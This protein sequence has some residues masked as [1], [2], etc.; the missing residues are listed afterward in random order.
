MGGTQKH[1][2]CSS[3]EEK[4]VLEGND[5][6]NLSYTMWGGQRS[7]GVICHK[8]SLSSNQEDLIQG[9]T[10]GLGGRKIVP[11][12]VVWLPVTSLVSLLPS[13]TDQ[14]DSVRHC[15]AG[16]RSGSGGG[17]GGG[18]EVLLG[19]RTPASSQTAN[20]QRQPGGT[21]ETSVPGSLLPGC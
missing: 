8:E 10:Q 4:R 17:G 16:P 7:P 6:Q 15:V 12:Q 11:D 5:L 9:T 20:T 3:H 1:E 14:P 18:V 19:I 13:L 21:T 2:G